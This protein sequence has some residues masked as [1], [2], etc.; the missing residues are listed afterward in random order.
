MCCASP[1]RVT[2]AS[3]LPCARPKRR[4]ET[5]RLRAQDRKT[6]LQLGM[7]EA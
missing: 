7:R 3:T 5:G 4:H 1:A 2:E 6:T